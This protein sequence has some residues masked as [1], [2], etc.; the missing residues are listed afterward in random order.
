MHVPLH[1]VTCSWRLRMP[2]LP[3]FNLTVAGSRSQPLT[4]PAFIACGATNCT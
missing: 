4:A 1:A 3:D 2:E